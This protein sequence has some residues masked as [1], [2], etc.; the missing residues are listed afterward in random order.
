MPKRSYS[1]A[2][3]ATLSIGMGAGAGA[4]AGSARAYKGVR[5]KP[6]Y[7]KAVKGAKVSAGVK[8]YVKRALRADEEE[9]I[10]P[11]VGLVA[12]YVTPV[13]GPLS[14]P[15]NIIALIP[16]I[17]T[18][19]TQGERVGSE[20]RPKAFSVKGIVNLSGKVNQAWNLRVRMMIVQD[21]SNLDFS[22]QADFTNA[23]ANS[24][25]M[26]QGGAGATVGYTGSLVQHFLPINTDRY[27][28]WYDTEFPLSSPVGQTSQQ[29]PLIAGAM[30]SMPPNSARS[31]DI[32]VK[33]P[34]T[35]KYDDGAGA[36]NWPLGSAPYLL[37]GWCNPD[38]P[39]VYSSNGPVPLYVTATSR[40]IYTDA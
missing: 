28:V 33:L 4:G 40:L 16:K 31:F 23:V 39:N 2:F 8:A 3:P 38:E 32:S 10:Q 37:I 20:I 29:S 7:R 24:L 19:V 34:T 25:L 6:K 11:G 27:K 14:S 30:A 26:D 9:K 1:S 5:S 22:Q 15:G 13:I 21:K 18:G 12:Q 17:A 35:L 36:T